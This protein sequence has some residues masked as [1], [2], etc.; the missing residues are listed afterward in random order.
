MSP[1]Y[2]DPGS[3]GGTVVYLG[4]EQNM[5]S[6]ELNHNGLFH[7]NRNE[8]YLGSSQKV[9]TWIEAIGY[10]YA[11]TYASVGEKFDIGG[12]GDAYATIEIF[13]DLLP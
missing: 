4:I 12:T 7:T 9:F 13:T 10:R 3:G 11:I 8:A 1:T 6:R 5:V 2:L